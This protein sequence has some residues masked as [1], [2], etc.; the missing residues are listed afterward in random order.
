MQDLAEELE[1]EGPLENRTHKREDNKVKFILEQATKAQ[2]RSRC[3][4]LLF[5]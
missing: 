1:I 5:L 3:I 2:R 4:A